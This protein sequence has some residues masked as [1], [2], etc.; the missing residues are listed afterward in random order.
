MI[1]DMSDCCIALETLHHIKQMT[2]DIVLHAELKPRNLFY[3]FVKC[4]MDVQ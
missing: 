4:E 2:V 1:H 3:I